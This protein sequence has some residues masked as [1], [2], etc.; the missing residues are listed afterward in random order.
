MFHHVTSCK[1]SG[2]STL[3][4][5]PVTT[6]R[7]KF[8]EDTKDVRVIENAY[9]TTATGYKHKISLQYG[10][11]L[12]ETRKY[13]KRDFYLHWKVISHQVHNTKFALSTHQKQLNIEVEF[14]CT[15]AIWFWSFL[16]GCHKSQ[17][18]NMEIQESSLPSFYCSRI[19]GLAPFRIKRNRKSH[20]EEI[21]FSSWLCFYTVCF[22]TTLG[23]LF[24]IKILWK[25]KISTKFW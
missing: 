9:S 25:S 20:I 22:L 12:I 7:T 21:Q 15:R 1:Q 19:F 18:V 23:A 14:I 2:W 6:G 8:V 13:V 10:G 3:S 24:E 16:G 4:H 11:N 5:T 17:I